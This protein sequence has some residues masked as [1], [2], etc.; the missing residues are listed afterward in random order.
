M[1]KIWPNDNFPR[2]FCRKKTILG[3]LWLFLFCFQ[4]CVIIKHH[5]DSGLKVNNYHVNVAYGIVGPNA[6]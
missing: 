4:V 2:K 6:K 1:Q 5:P 3:Y